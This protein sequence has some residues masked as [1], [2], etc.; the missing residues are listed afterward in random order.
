V[1]SRVCKIDH[2]HIG[3]A[4]GLML[5]MAAI[6]GFF[7]PIIF[8]HLVPRTSYNTGWLFLAGISFVFALAGLAGHNPASALKRWAGKRS[9]PIAVPI[10]SSSNLT[11]GK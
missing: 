6:G 3:T 1:P 2:A 5:T 9:E 10:V 11:L 4:F 8:G 7:V